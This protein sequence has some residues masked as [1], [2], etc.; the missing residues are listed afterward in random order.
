MKGKDLVI[1]IGN[2]G[3]GKSTTIN[4]LIGCD[5]YRNEKDNIAVKND[6]KIPPIVN[7]GHGF[8]SETFIPGV[9]A[10][11]NGITY[12]DCP[13]FKDNRGEEINIANA[14]NIRNMVRDAKSV[15]ALIL[16]EFANLISN[17]AQNLSELIKISTKLF[18]GE[19]SLKKNKNSLIVGVTKLNKDI[20]TVHY[21]KNMKSLLDKYFS[22]SIAG[23]LRDRVITFDPL[24]F[25]IEGGVR[26]DVIID[27][28]KKLNPIEDHKKM[29]GTILLDSDLKMLT[30]ASYK[31]SDEIDNILNKE[32]NKIKIEDFILVKEQFEYML[33]FNIIEHKGVESLL[34]HIENNIASKF[35]SI[36][37]EFTQL[38]GEGKIEDADRLF[39]LL[40]N[41]MQLFNQE[42]QS[43]VDHIS[44]KK[45]KE[46]LDLKRKTTK[47]EN[48]KEKK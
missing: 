29:F 44:L 20:G 24:E 22:D 46:S 39:D 13:G 26:R 38:Y 11:Y 37:K 10:E 43:K 25:I 42:I 33:Y 45:Y 31:I 8:V 21:V 17:R 14:I 32:P 6:S 47:E 19:E 40:T 5:M 2:T 35:V 23:N 27:M 30:E 3:A 7:I 36:S 18:N 15:R 4:Y 48:E 16:I 41:S 1:V 28:I 9:S 34:K 12:A